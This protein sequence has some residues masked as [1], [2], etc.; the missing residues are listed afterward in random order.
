MEIKWG[1]VRTESL[2]K[3][4]KTKFII[5]TK[6]IVT[7]G[8]EMVASIGSVCSDEVGLSMCVISHVRCGQPPGTHTPILSLK[9]I[10]HTPAN[11]LKILSVVI[12]ILAAL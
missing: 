1:F 5:K 10:Q 6:C 8:W 9:V 7:R 11:S 2:D 12:C 3:A 4:T